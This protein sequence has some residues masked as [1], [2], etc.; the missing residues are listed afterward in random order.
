MA[1]KPAKTTEDRTTGDNGPS[2]RTR[3]TGRR[4]A[5][6]ATRRP[7]PPIGLRF[8][9]RNTRAGVDPMSEVE[10]E[11]RTASITNEKGEVI[12]EQRDVEIPARWSQM[13]T[14]VVVSK[15]F[16]G[17]LGT[18]DRERSVRQLIG[19]V[20]NTITEWGSGC[21]YFA[22]TEDEDTF[23]A[24]L[25]HL[26]LHQKMAFNSPVWFNCGVEAHPQCSACFINSVQDTMD[27]IMNLAKTEG[28]LFKWGSGTGTN[29]SPIRSSREK[30]RGGGTASGPVSFMKGYDAF[31]GVIK[32]GGKTRRAAKMVI[33]NA[34]HPDIVDFIRCKELEEKKAWA[35]I[36]S[37]YDSSFNGEAYGSVFFQNSNNSVRVTDEQMK[38]VG[39]DGDWNTRS[40]L[41]G[42]VM[43]RHRARDMMNMI[44]EAAWICGDPGLQFHTTINRWHTCPNTAPINASNP[45][46]EYMFLDDSACNLA[47]LNLM[48]FRRSDGEF[49]GESF[50]HAVDITI[51]AQEI[52][53]GNASY[54]TP[55]IGR[56]SE[57]YRPLGLG[58]AN[59]GALLMARGLPYDS[60]AGRAMAAAITA[61]MHG[62]AYATSA[63]I[64]AQMGPFNG[65]E[66][67]REPMLGVIDMHKAAVQDIDSSLVPNDLM[68]AAREVWNRARTLGGEYGYKNSQVTVLAPTGTIGFMMD[69]DTTGVEPEIALVKYKKLVGGGLLKIVNQTVTEALL[70]LG[71]SRIE[72]KKITEYLDEHETIEG[73]PG[74][75][76]EHLPVFD[77]AFRAAAGTRSIHYRGHIRM[78]AAVQPFLSGA[79]S[80]TVNMPPDATPQEIAETYMEAWKLGLKSIAI[81]RDG[82][83]RTQPLNT[84]MKGKAAEEVTGLEVA[85]S[86][87]RRHL[88]DE[89]HALTHKFSIAGHEG[90]L[91]VGM[92]EDG[93]PGEIFLVM[94]KEGSVVSGLMDAFATGIS[95]ALQYGVPLKALINKFSHVRY[96]PSGFTRN[97]EIPYAKSIT[98]YVFRWLASRFLTDEEKRDIG[99]QLDNDGATS[100]PLLKSVAAAPESNENGGTNGEVRAGFDNQ[101]DAPPCSECGSTLVRNG[102]CYKCLNCGA[103]AGCS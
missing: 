30:L 19:R 7:S 57:D 64:A 21:G 53:V 73:A 97:P 43:E 77:C 23:R 66:R 60:D 32:S 84:S 99:I 85:R 20:A 2:S 58:Y 82:C 78:M 39:E 26:L 81:Y 100:T 48:K 59:L 10:W 38:N 1:R 41:S 8:E 75:K 9:R 65:Y 89:R 34:D 37:G 42:D 29:L 49:D 70:R 93:S 15:Y 16:R 22:G 69:C 44:A 98:D 31:A 76:A 11:L 95:L 86:P 45:C 6:R 12:F 83:K 55:A 18:P 14:N 63:R 13:A 103:T 47:S 52:I 67:N 79:I 72:A 91:T 87:H 80:K 101:S 68:S 28:M 94:A 50:R 25:T 27:S 4:T 33:L 61:L 96:E 90:Y 40:V 71:Y 51:A 46:S 92:Y 35:L 24:E 17:N 54:P 56:N 88:P 74:L 5:R 62:Q 102:A 36:D 3:S